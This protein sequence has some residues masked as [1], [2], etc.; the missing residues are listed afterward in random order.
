MA[1]LVAGFS[2][3]E[4]EQ[5][6][7]A[8][9]RK[10]SREYMLSIRQKFLEGQELMGSVNLMPQMYT[11]LE[12]FFAL[13]GFCKSHAFSFANIT[14]QSAYLRCHFP[15]YYYAALLNNQPMGFYSSEVLVR[16]ARSLG[17]EFMN[18]DIQNSEFN[19]FVSNKKIRW[20]SD[21]IWNET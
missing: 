18:V 1:S 16:D 21:G 11:R 6:R 14:Y 10:R 7:K 20:I 5:L 8:M 19:N 12:G 13:Y 15:A 2:A 3:G 17:L 9:S 4:A